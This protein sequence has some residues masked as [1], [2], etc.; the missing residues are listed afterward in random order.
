MA[1]WPQR[2][3]CRDRPSHRPIMMAHRV[4]VNF[5]VTAELCLDHNLAMQGNAKYATHAGRWRPLALPVASHESRE[6]RA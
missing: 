1:A 6:A 2:L 4:A 5:K 3:V